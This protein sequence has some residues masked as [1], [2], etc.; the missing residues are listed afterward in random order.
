MLFYHV[1]EKTHFQFDVTL[2]GFALNLH[3]YI[4][5]GLL[6]VEIFFF[7][8]GFCLMLPYACWMAGRRPFQSWREYCSRRFWKIVPSYYFALAII[9]IWYPFNSPPGLNRWLDVALH[10]F[11]AHSFNA[12][13]FISLNGNFWS[14]AVEVQFY[15]LFPLIVLAFIRKPIVTIAAVICAGLFYSTATAATYHDILFQWA[16]EMPS[17]L[18]L[19]GLGMASAYIYERWIARAQLSDDVRSQMA[20]V[21]IACVL[22]LG[23][24]FEQMNRMGG[25]YPVWSWQNGH[26]FEIGVVLAIFTLSATCAPAW[27]QN[28]V[29]NKALTFY[30]DISYNMY[31]WNAAVVAFFVQYWWGAGPYYSGILLLVLVLASTTVIGWM[32]TRVLERPLMRY[33]WNA[34]S[35]LFE[36]VLALRLL[37]QRRQNVG[38]VSLD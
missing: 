29:A 22:T 6:G 4:Q 33:R 30:S 17:F 20:I 9:A 3:T 34:P 1:W 36:N 35:R 32:L 25:G 16:Y 5:A 10:L 2:F 38:G 19:F 12:A 13:S 7:V 14:L 18:P 21:A 31:L 11:F 28:A 15:V 27:L 37:W 24:L 8:S 26:R 23:Y